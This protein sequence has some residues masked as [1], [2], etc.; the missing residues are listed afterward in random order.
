MGIEWELVSFYIFRIAII[1]AV[2]RRMT[3]CFWFIILASQQVQEL[4]LGLSFLL[5]LAPQA[6]KPEWGHCQLPSI[7]LPIMRS[8]T[9]KKTYCPHWETNFEPGHYL[10]PVSALLQGRHKNGLVPCSSHLRPCI[11]LPVKGLNSLFSQWMHV[12]W[13]NN[14]R[15]LK[16]KTE[17]SHCKHCTGISK[18][19]FQGTHL[20]LNLWVP[21]LRTGSAFPQCWWSYT[22]R[23]GWK[24]IP[25]DLQG[26][27]VNC[28]LMLQNKSILTWL[29]FWGF[30][31]HSS[32]EFQ[33]FYL[34]LFSTLRNYINSLLGMT[35]GVI[36]RTLNPKS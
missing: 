24:E 15:S 32:M 20:F 1:H 13:G 7:S 22:S 21:G 17:G 2:P 36:A 29:L 23:V 19:F 14:H 12:T 30:P 31:R 28:Y 8:E 3:Y 16:R 34:S 4:L 10:S 5:A 6:R 27:I 25:F 35:I 9:R 26:N 11:Q 18:H 33:L